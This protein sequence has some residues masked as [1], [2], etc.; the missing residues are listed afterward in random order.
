MHSFFG[1]NVCVLGGNFFTINGNVTEDRDGSRT[2]SGSSSTSYF[3]ADGTPTRTHVTGSLFRGND[4]FRPINSAMRFGAPPGMSGS[5]QEGGIISMNGPGTYRLQK[6]CAGQTIRKNGTGGLTVLGGTDIGAILYL[7]GS[8]SIT[9]FG[10]IYPGVVIHKHGASDL[11]IMS[12]QIADSVQFN[13]HQGNVTF[14]HRPPESV[15]NTIVLHGPA[16]ISMPT[17]SSNANA[18][19]G[20]SP[21]FTVIDGAHITVDG[22][23]AHQPTLQVPREGTFSPSS[24]TSPS[25][26]PKPREN[27]N[28]NEFSDALNIYLASLKGKTTIK[29]QMEGLQL[30]SAERELLSDLYKPI[31]KLA[32]DYI[33]SLDWL[34]V[35][36]CINEKFYNL[37]DLLRCTDSQDQLQDPTTRAPICQLQIQPARNLINEFEEL[38]SELKTALEVHRRETSRKEDSPIPPL[39]SESASGCPELSHRW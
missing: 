18:G 28:P 39:S 33:I 21:P 35:P 30:T 11:T 2:V 26:L 1:P 31:E 38:F 14:I 32:Y 17:D 22:N 27:V 4:L 3:G 19:V 10:Q 36:V 5:I 20:Q 7:H 34:K 6:I 13:I 9:L 37:D 24:F 29:E 23:I 15:V 16:R 12:R 8:G 25:K